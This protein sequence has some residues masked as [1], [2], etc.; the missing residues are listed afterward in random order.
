MTRRIAALA[1]IALVSTLGGAPAASATVACQARSESQVFSPWGDTRSYFP[2]AGGTFEA[3]TPSW[4]LSGGAAVVAG[5]EPWNRLGGT[6]SLSL[7]RGAA[8]AQSDAHCLTAT[9]EA[10]RFFVKR[11]GVAGARLHLYINVRNPVNG[12]VGTLDND[13]DGAAAGWT[14]GQMLYIPDLLASSGTVYVYV[15]LEARGTSAAWQ[16]DD[17]VIDPYKGR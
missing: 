11:P 13:I 6:R 15:R 2:L 5:N 7:P 8:A 10:I 1:A 12:A 14:A 16:V 9:E 4:S 3:G 17:V